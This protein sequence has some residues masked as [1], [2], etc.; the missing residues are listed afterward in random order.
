MLKLKKKKVWSC[1]IT[2]IIFN[3][4]INRTNGKQNEYVITFLGFE[5]Y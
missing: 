2:V 5:R 4:T 1:G 3:Y